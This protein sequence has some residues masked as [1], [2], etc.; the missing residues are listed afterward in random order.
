MTGGSLP[1]QTWHDIMTVAHQG[2]EIRELAG[3]GMGQKVPAS[4]KP[5]TV[6]QKDKAPEIKP[7]PPPVL[8]RRGAE[9][10]VQVEKQLD[11]VAKT[12]EKTTDKTS[13]NEPG[14]TGKPSSGQAS[15]SELPFPDNL[16]AATGDA[17]AS[18]KN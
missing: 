3:V 6:A 15:S 14:K 10:L 7:G 11:D 18:R 2:I 16:A 8:T 1:A 9:V 13:A 12:L 5:Q 17:P 4:E